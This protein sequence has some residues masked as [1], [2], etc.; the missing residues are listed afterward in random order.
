MKKFLITLVLLA[1]AVFFSGFAGVKTLR[2][3]VGNCFIV[4]SETTYQIHL[5]QGG[6]SGFNHEFM[7]ETKVYHVGQEPEYNIQ[8][9]SN[10]LILTTG[11]FVQF[12]IEGTLCELG[13]D[14][15]G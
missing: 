10:P 3:D 14:P 6:F 1:I 13:G 5:V 15:R 7:T 11:D 9:Y 2:I 12:P 4:D 8:M